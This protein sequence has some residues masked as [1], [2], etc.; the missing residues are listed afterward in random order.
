MP[1]GAECRTEDLLATTRHQGGP[2][3]SFLLGQLGRPQQYGLQNSPEQV[4]EALH[5]RDVARLQ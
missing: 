2:P 5:R 3:S 1:R 4:D